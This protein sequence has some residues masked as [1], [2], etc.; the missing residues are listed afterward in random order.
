MSTHVAKTCVTLSLLV[1]CLASTDTAAAEP[2]LRFSRHFPVSPAMADRVR[3]W[4]RVFTEVSQTEAVLHDRDDVGVVYDVVPYGPGGASEP[5]EVA[6]AS[7][8]HVLVTM[9]IA[10]LYRPFV[11]PPVDHADVGALWTHRA[12]GP[13][14]AL[15]ASGNIRAQRGLKEVFSAGL[16]RAELYLPSIRKVF[17]AHRLPEELVYLPHVESSF[18]PNA[19][20]RAG[21]AGLWQLTSATATPLLKSPAGV[22]HRL[23]PV[24]STE[25]AARH[26][27]RAYKV[28]GNWPL[29][30]TAYNHGVAGM[31]RARQAVGGDSLDDIVRGYESERFGFASKNFYAEF[32][33]AVHVARNARFYFPK[34]RPEPSLRYVVRPG[35]SLWTIAR[36][37][38]VSVRALVAANNLGGTKLRAGQLIVIRRS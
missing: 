37:H 14:A 11:I 23:D 26:L 17:R 12:S 20:S 28:L 30:V 25:I 10:E 34:L 35:D 6:R 15:R 24:R 2:P 4:V 1:V 22:D 38:R 8:R 29:T 31:L 21:A 36:K 13:S 27:A 32:L 5:V 3:F 19:V 18:N 9:G 7:Y 16:V 33:A